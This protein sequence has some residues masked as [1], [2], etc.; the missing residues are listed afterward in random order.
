MIY[1]NKLNTSGLFRDEFILNKTT[2]FQYSNV[3]ENRFTLQKKNNLWKY[4]FDFRLYFYSGEIE[5][6]YGNFNYKLVRG[7]IKYFSNIGTFIIGKTYVNFGNYSIFNPFDMDKNINF[8]DISYDKE[9]KLALVYDF[10]FSKLSGGKVYVSPNKDLQYS[11]I[12]SS[13]Y[14]NI[15][16]FDLGFIINRYKRDNIITGISFKGDLLLTIFGNIAQH[17]NDNFQK[18]FLEANIG[19]EH[20]IGNLFIQFI[21]YFNE[22]GKDRISQYTFLYNNDHYFQAKHYGF[23]NISYMYDYFLN[24][25]GYSFINFIDGSSLDL[26]G[27]DITI[28]NGFNIFL[29]IFAL[30]GT[31]SEEFSA[32]LYG[33]YGILCRFQVKF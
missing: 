28:N 22:I 19:L 27:S 32:S 14:F 17:F 31:G 4:Y 29:E 33:S 30:T 7:F 10:S 18:K 13:I 9:G 8:N 16:K 1:G 2:N 25:Y 11:L 15:L 12:G 23:V 5:S 3:M 24:F 26:I 6:L 20:Y 21:Y